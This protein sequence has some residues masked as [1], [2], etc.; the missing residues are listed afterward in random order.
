M[1]IWS[2]SAAPLIMGNDV[3]NVS[4]ESRAILVN[5]E[6]IAVDQDM[7][8]KMG[9]RILNSGYQIW[10]RPLENGDIAVALYNALGA[11]PAPPAQCP[12]WNH[13]QGYYLESCAGNIGCY[14]GTSDDLKAQCCGNSLCAGVSYITAQN[15]GCLKLDTKCGTTNGTGYEGWFKPNFTPATCGPVDIPID[16]SIL[17]WAGATVKVRDI[18]A[19]A[20]V[21][22]FTGTYTAKAV[23]CHGTAFLRLTKA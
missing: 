1:A 22:S 7:L 19:R 10:S 20:D 15:F 4:A 12:T 11:P 2:I 18:W 8:G 3:R 9:Y 5:P 6:A 21:G 23:P 13:T 17:G 16:F 14:D